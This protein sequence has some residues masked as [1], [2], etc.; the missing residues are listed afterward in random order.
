MANKSDDQKYKEL[1]SSIQELI[2]VELQD[3][4]KTR[5]KFQRRC[6]R[7]K[8]AIELVRKKEMD[9]SLYQRQLVETQRI[10]SELIVSQET[11]FDIIQQMVHHHNQAVVALVPAELVVAYKIDLS[12]WMDDLCVNK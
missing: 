8:T 7:I 12:T 4:I 9:E 3:L 1:F 2:A 11:S 6:D 10:L 5:R